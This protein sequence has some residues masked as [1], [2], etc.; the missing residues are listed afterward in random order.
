[1]IVYGKSAV[2]QNACD[3]GADV[4]LE[5]TFL[6]DLFETQ[7]PLSKVYTDLSLV[8][9]SLS[10]VELEVKNS[11]RSYRAMINSDTMIA[12]ANLKSSL[13]PEECREY[14]GENPPTGC[15]WRML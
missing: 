3:V 15:I 10:Y 9:S 4:D 2:Q 14:V 7:Q 5:H 13:I 1:V 8:A 6:S 12:V 11:P